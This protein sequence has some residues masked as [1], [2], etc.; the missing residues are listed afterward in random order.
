MSWRKRKKTT[1]LMIRCMPS[2]RSKMRNLSECAE[3]TN[4]FCAVQVCIVFPEQPDE[5]DKSKD[6]SPYQK[7]RETD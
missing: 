5:D 7:A 3:T 4:H 2:H 1:P 6:N